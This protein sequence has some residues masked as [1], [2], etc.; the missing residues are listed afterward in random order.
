VEPLGRLTK[1]DKPFVSE[2]EQQL[3]FETMV[4][5]FTTAPVLRHFDYDWE[6]SIETEASDSV[7]AGHLSQ[8]DDEGVLHLVTYFWKKHSP[9][10]CNYDI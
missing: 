4:N 1:K 10:E 7:S 3:A 5:N 8:Y 6:V 2:A 9:A